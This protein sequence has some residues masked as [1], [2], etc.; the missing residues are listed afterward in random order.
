MEQDSVES[1][2]VSFKLKK[3][4]S[5]W[6]GKLSVGYEWSGKLTA[7]SVEGGLIFQSANSLANLFSSLKNIQILKSKMAILLTNVL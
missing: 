6:S 4:R 5:D 2:S 7:A 1:T 3:L